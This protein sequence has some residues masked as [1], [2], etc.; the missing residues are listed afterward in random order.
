MVKKELEILDQT[1]QP[2]YSKYLVESIVVVTLVLNRTRNVTLSIYV[3]LF[4]IVIM[5]LLDRQKSIISS[6]VRSYMGYNFVHFISN[7]KITNN[8]SL[9]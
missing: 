6:S 7:P 4:F 8:M 9:F 3:G 2:N 5:Y 1:Q